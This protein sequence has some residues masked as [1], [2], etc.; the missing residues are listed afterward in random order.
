MSEKKRKENADKFIEELN[1]LSEKYNIHV[2]GIGNP[3]LVDDGGS[4]CSIMF[5]YRTMKYRSYKD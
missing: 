5:D 1:K 3:W 4:V 2:E